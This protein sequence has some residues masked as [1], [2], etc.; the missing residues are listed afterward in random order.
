MTDVESGGVESTIV[1]LL[2]SSVGRRWLLKAGLGAGALGAAAWGV[3]RWAAAGSGPVPRGLVAGVAGSSESRVLQFALGAAAELDDLMVHANGQRVALA[4]HSPLTRMR[5]LGEG[6]LWRKLRRGRLTHYAQVELP[7]D[8][9]LVVTVQGTRNGQRV[10]VAQMFHAP[11]AATRALAQAAFELGGSYEAVTGCPSR[12]AE[13][14]LPPILVVT[15]DEVV[16][17]D[18]VV[19]SLT[20]AVTMSMLHPNVAT[21][22]MME[23]PATKSLLSNTASV[24]TLGSYIGQMQQNGQDYA[25]LTPAVDASGNP[26][27]I[28]VGSVT[29]TFSTVGLTQTDSTFTATAQSAFVDSIHGVRDTGTPLGTVITKPLD[30]LQDTTD[31]ATWHQSEGVVPTSTPYVPPTGV[32]DTVQVNVTKPYPTLWYGTYTKAGELSGNQLPLTLYNNYV[33]WVWVYVQYLKADGT[34]L[35]LDPSAS[36][37]NTP[38]AKNVGLLPQIFTLLGIP[39]WDTNTI[40]PTLEFPAEATSARLLFCGLGNDA[41]DGGWTQYFPPDAYPAGQIAP[42]KEVLFPA[43]VTG[44]FTIGLTAFALLTDIDIAATW[45]T[46]RDDRRRRPRRRGTT[47]WKRCSRPRS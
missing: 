11:T 23:V 40:T 30:E 38:N 14:G 25:T 45:A 18:S 21:I 3:P 16:A 4:P 41:I 34:N 47:A 24:C 37:P 35:N 8:R 7:A 33:R 31:T 15:E 12:L 27:S 39:I 13:L 28:K 46:I 2:G 43:L 9:G 26:V 20:T 42:Q 10:L 36:F 22:G 19:D 32:G 17:L 44:I 29:T 5:L 1:E 6:T